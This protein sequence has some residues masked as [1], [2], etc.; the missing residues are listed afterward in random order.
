MG[1][2]HKM[3][4]YGITSNLLPYE[5]DGPVNQ[6]KMEQIVT[7]LRMEDDKLP[8]GRFL[9]RQIV[10]VS[11][12]FIK[13]QVENASKTTRIYGLHLMIRLHE[14]RYLL[15][16]VPWQSNCR[17]SNKTSAEQKDNRDHWATVANRFYLGCI[18]IL[19]VVA[20]IAI[21]PVAAAAAVAI[22]GAVLTKVIPTWSCNV[23]PLSTC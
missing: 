20:S 3:A 11:P 18:Q 5:S 9:V 19:K 15:R 21:I 6:S 23:V 1:W 22:A 14:K 17:A 12:T 8:S 13:R 4:M 16:F 2:Q 7:T 10:A